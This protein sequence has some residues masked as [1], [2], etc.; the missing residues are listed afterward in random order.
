MDFALASEPKTEA[1]WAQPQAFAQTEFDVDILNVVQR[2][3]ESLD[4]RTVF[5]CFGQIIA[6]HMPLN[7]IQLTTTEYHFKW[8]AQ[9]GIELPRYMNNADGEFHLVYN[10]RKPLSPRKALLLSKLEDLMI[11]PMSNALRFHNVS[12][13]AMFDELTQLGNRHYYQQ[14]LDKALAR[15]QRNQGQLSLIVIDLDNFKQIN[16]THG[17]LVGDEVL[18]SFAKLL[19]KTIR[20]TDQAFRV[21]GDEFIVI[22]QGNGIAASLVC[23]RIL[24]NLN[25]SAQLQE[26]TVRCSLGITTAKLEDSSD[27]LYARADK[28]MYQAKAYGKNQ[29]QLI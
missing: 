25:E 8:G 12:R 9:D 1:I 27:S 19:A 5:A 21:G 6:Q 16:D 10:L 15:S 20:N 4:P 23:E 14:V 11:K 26:L 13:Q 17:H 24:T 28:A 18:T 29:Y 3:H 7:G 22:A 2:L